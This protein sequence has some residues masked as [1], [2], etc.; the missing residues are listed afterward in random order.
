MENIKNFLFKQLQD[1]NIIF[2]M[3]LHSLILFTFLTLF[4]SFYVSKIS[5]DVFNEEVNNIINKLT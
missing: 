5:T 1:P 3:I 2:D 4:F